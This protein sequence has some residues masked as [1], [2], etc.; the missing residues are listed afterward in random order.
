[1]TK[2]KKQSYIYVS[3]RRK[4]AAARVRLFKGTGETE[5]NGKPIAEY[6]PGEVS[7]TIWSK[8]F[9]I[10]G[11]WGKYY[12]TI[13]VIGGGKHGQVEAVAHGL[14]KAFALL[15]KDD[16]RAPLKKA[17]LLTRDSR[18][19]QRRMVGTGGKARRKKQSPKR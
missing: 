8:P 13:R 12:A 11:S 4:C 6:F 19:R 1:M 5:V 16:L 7:K 9:E 15:N 2:A 10:T 3:G 14:A 18:I 17:G